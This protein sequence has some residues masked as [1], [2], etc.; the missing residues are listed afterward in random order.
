MILPPDKKPGE[1]EVQLPLPPQII[2]LADLSVTV[3]GEPSESVGLRGEKLVWSG[4]LQAEPSRVVVTYTAVGRGIFSL[5]RISEV[6]T[7]TTTP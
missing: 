3:N 4:P 5:N 7:L 2:S 6:P 1:A